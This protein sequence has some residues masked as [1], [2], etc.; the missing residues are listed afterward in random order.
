MSKFSIY[1]PEDIENLML[2][3]SFDELYDKE[4]EFVLRHISSEEEYEQMRQVLLDVKASENMDESIEP[5]AYMRK[6]LIEEFEAH[7]RHNPL[8]LLFQQIQAVFKMPAFQIGFATVSLFLFVMIFVKF[9]NKSDNIELAQNKDY[10]TETTSQ[11]PTVTES[12]ASDESEF[13]E[14]I[15]IEEDSRKEIIKDA[16]DNGRNFIGEGIVVLEEKYDFIAEEE[17]TQEI[18]KNALADESSEKQEMAVPTSSSNITR[19]S[20]SNISVN[21]EMVVVNTKDNKKSIFNREKNNRFLGGAK[22]QSIT[23]ESCNLESNKDVFFGIMYAA[24]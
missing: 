2:N 24:M 12:T 13:T 8:I 23:T 15:I 14:E 19:A 3:K 22:T 20:S 6:Q 9:N 4:K 21:D 18:D 1:D 10:N 17:T 7:K 16:E 5:P 11:T